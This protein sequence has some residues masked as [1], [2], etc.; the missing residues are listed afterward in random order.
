MI[1]L[2]LPQPQR[3][4]AMTI[5]KTKPRRPKVPRY[6]L[7]DQFNYKSRLNHLEED[8]FFMMMTNITPAARTRQPPM[9]VN[10]IVPMPP[11]SGSLVG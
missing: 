2:R 1:R 5:D 6:M 7:Y 10:I 4:F 8:F 9:M 11:V 3:G